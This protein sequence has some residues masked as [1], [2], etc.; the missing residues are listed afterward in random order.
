M[1][2]CKLEVWVGGCVGGWVE[3]CGLASGWWEGDF[4][5]RATTFIEGLLG[6]VDD[7]LV[8]SFFLASLY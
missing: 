8:S 6:W 4:F 2:Y 5:M 3:M 1:S 7:W